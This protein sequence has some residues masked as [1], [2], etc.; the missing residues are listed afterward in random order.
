MRF[1]RIKDSIRY[2]IAR[3]RPAWALIRIALHTCYSEWHQMKCL[4][5]SIGAR[6]DGRMRAEI[7][8]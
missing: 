6:M 2:P 4:G 8:G 7:F 1:T 3:N 5:D